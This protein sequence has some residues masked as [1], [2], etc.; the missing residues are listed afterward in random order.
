[1]KKHSLIRLERISR[2]ND[3]K[4]LFE[5]GSSFCIYPIRVRYVIKP[6][7]TFSGNSIMVSVPKRHYKRAVDRNLLKRKIRESYRL[8]KEL[9]SD[10]L[11]PM[12]ITFIYV[13][14]QSYSFDFINEKLILILNR[15]HNNH[16]DEK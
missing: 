8:N 5:K 4:E 10:A 2:S 6:K 11:I 14:K 9:L 13:G 3:I 12:N 1:M 16:N 15:L 7:S